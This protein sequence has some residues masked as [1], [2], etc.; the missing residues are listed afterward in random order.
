MSGRITR[1]ASSL[2]ACGLAAL[3]L[4]TSASACSCA[5]LP[6]KEIFR[7]SDGALVAKLVRV[8][9]VGDGFTSDYVFRVVE[10]LKK[11]HLQAGN[12]GKRLMSTAAPVCAAAAA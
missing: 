11:R 9:P 5:G 10:A 3:A 2:A 4:S 8:Q 7:I 12:G 6:G 1:L